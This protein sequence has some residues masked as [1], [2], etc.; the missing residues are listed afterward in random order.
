M[1]VIRNRVE[2][3]RIEFYVE[4]SILDIINQPSRGSV[5]NTAYDVAWQ[6]ILKTYPYVQRDDYTGCSY[7]KAYLILV[8]FFQKNKRTEDYPNLVS[9]WKNESPDLEK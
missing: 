8:A 2:I 3:E 5:I 6:E 4:L 9:E 7:K 1:N